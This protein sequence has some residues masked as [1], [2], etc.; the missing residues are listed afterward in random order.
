MEIATRNRN[1]TE[2]SKQHESFCLSCILKIAAAA[3]VEISK[4]TQLVYLEKLRTLSPESLVQA[5]SRTIEEWDRPHMMPPIAFIRA[6]AI[7]NGAVHAEA[8]WELLQ[9]LIYRDW[10]PDVGWTRKVDLDEQME[11]A[12]RQVGGLRRI[13]DCETK[14]F[15]FLRRD[16]LAA[17]ARFGEECGEQVRLSEKRA[18]E[19]VGELYEALPQPPKQLTERAGGFQQ[20]AAPEPKKQP[21]REMPPQSQQEYEQRMELLRRQAEQLK[22]P[23]GA[24]Q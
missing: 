20:V 7:E 1:T 15:Q 16:F 3:T 17:Y 24:A 4:A 6:R 2:T 18:N 23:Q 11:F 22:Q 19:L 12:I 5:T 13:H 10:H 9:K 8:A 21:R 14:N